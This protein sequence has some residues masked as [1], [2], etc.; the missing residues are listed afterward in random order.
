VNECKPLGDGGGYGGGGD[1]YGGDGGGGGGGGGVSGSAELPAR[2]QAGAYTRSRLSSTSAT[3][4][5]IHE[6]SRDIR[7]TGVLKLSCYGNECQPLRPGGFPHRP[8]R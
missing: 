4:Q 6:L 1:R 2:G 5:H 3:A 7:W 8:R